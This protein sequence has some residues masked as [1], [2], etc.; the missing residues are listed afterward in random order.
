MVPQHT[1]ARRLLALLPA[2][3]VVATAVL[4]AADGPGWRNDRPMPVPVG[5]HRVALLGDRVLSAG[6]TTWQRGRKRWL[7]DVWA[8]APADDTRTAVGSLPE[9]VGDGVGIGD[10]GALYVLGGVTA[11]RP[12]PDATGCGFTSVG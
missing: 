4:A 10:G 1:Q 8:Y 6:G 5:G 11:R 9:P 3:L 7:R 12:P 2:G